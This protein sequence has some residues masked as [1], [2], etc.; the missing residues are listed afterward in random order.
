[1]IQ[2]EK[3][4]E[5]RQ[6]I[7][8]NPKRLQEQKEV[9]K[10]YGKLFNPMNLDNLTSEDF[11]S[12]LLIKNNRH[13]EGIHRQ[14]NMIT[15]DMDKLKNGLK[16]LLDEKRDIKERLNF[17]FPQNKT[18]YIKGLGR[19]VITPILLVVY[20][21][22]YGVYNSKSEHYLKEFGLL[23]NF[24]KKSFAEK[25]VEVNQILNE[26]ALD[27]KVNLWQLDSIIGCLALGD[28][29]VDIAENKTLDIID[30]V[31]E[32]KLE[33][34]EEFG[35]E[36]HLED[37]LVENWEK[38]F[39]NEEFSILEEDGD[40]IGQQFSTPV[41]IID[42]LAKRK[43]G[44]GWLVIELKKGR[45]GDRVVGQLLRYIGWVKKEKAQDGDEVKGLIIVGDKTDKLRYALETV[46]N[47]DLMVYSVNFKLSKSDK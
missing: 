3:I 38:L 25:Y 1:M 19:A 39:L 7:L 10:K 13:W 21:E 28:R 45:S 41:G 43:D 29:L 32:E 26:L 31:D 33:I 44:K 8:N 6:L 30:E 24:R 35:L 14:G 9:I 16:I 17:L 47:I 18:H 4:N 11:K 46:K 23:P 36:S 42:I 5:W 22:K 37:F 27:Y 34:Y 40:I 20:P 15:A 12:F 2:K